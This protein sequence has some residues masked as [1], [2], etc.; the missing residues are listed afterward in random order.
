MRYRALRS[1]GRLVTTAA[2]VATFG[3]MPPF[4]SA[5]ALVMSEGRL[6]VVLDPV[7]R[8]PTLPGGHVR[9]REIPEDAVVR[10]VQEETGIRIRVGGLVSALAGEDAACEKG[11]VRLIYTGEVIGGDLRS[12]GEGEASWMRLTDASAEM[13]RDAPI[14]RSWLDE[15][16]FRAVR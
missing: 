2:A 9:W 7:R 3:R 12:S 4:V 6:L 8:E 11:V 1:L 10:E 14:I 15:R 16:E 13:V 5:S